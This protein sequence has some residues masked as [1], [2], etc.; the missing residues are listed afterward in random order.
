MNVHFFLFFAI[1]RCYMTIALLVV[2]QLS[3]CLK[4]RLKSNFTISM[5]IVSF[6]ELFVLDDSRVGRLCRPLAEATS[7]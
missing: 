1:A 4:T 7:L 5:Q 6:T 3:C 2:E